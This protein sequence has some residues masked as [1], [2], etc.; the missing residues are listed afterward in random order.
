MITEVWDGV[1]WAVC[2]CLTLELKAVVVR[3]AQ[4]G[5]AVGGGEH[6][7]THHP[8]HLYGIDG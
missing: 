6:G 1:L 3:S 4:D 7:A 8:Q 5:A 2:S